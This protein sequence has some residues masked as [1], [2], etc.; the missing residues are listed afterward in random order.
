TTTGKLQLQISMSHLWE[1]DDGYREIIAA[2]GVNRIG[3]VCDREY[4]TGQ[5]FDKCASGVSA[6]RA[7]VM[8]SI[9]AADSMMDL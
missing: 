6:Y 4:I 9:D 7:A 5:G 1:F 8:D 3:W 2:V